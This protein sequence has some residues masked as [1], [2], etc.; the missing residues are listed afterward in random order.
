MLWI[1]E[2][3][4][5]NMLIVSIKHTHEKS[6][7]YSR[8]HNRK[9]FQKCIKYAPM[10][11]K[12]CRFPSTHP[13]SVTPECSFCNRCPSG[14]WVGGCLYVY[15]SWKLFSEFVLIKCSKFG[16]SFVGTKY[17]WWLLST[18]Y[19]VFKVSVIILTV[20]HPAGLVICAVLSLLFLFFLIYQPFWATSE[21]QQWALQVCAKHL[22]FIWL[23]VNLNFHYG[24][25][26]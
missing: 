19:S 14:G 21:L 6:L 25:N 8:T 5:F 12:L 23:C 16:N 22:N 26:S 10:A 11:C 7:I 4:D 13:V 17:I 24:C 3:W 1:V 20:S 9:G 2:Y 18:G 15:V